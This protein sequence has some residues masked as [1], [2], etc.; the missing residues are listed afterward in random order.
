[1]AAAFAVLILLTAVALLVLLRNFAGQNFPDAVAGKRLLTEQALRE[2]ETT[3]E[4]YVQSIDKLVRLAE[5][6]IEPPATPLLAS[7]REK[8]LLIDDAI[9]DCRAAAEQN[10]YNAH[11]RL[12][13]LAMYREKQQTLQEIMKENANELR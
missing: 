2:I 5:V 12:E 13:L 7:Y 4:A 3:Q 1:M 9:A 8:L 10:H 6:R 11:L